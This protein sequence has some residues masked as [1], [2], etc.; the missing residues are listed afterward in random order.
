MKSK[1]PYPGFPPN[2]RDVE[3]T[4]GYRRTCFVLEFM[5]LGPLE[6]AEMAMINEQMEALADK[7]RQNMVA[8]EKADFVTPDRF[9]RILRDGLRLPAKN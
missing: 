8:I 5:S 6:P 2:Y 3:D 4:G 7:L 1:K 9:D